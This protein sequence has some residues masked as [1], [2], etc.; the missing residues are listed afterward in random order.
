V[1]AHLPPILART[2]F[3]ISALVGLACACIAPGDAALPTVAPSNVRP[4]VSVTQRA[5][6]DTLQGVVI[7]DPL[8]W[9]EDTSTAEVQAWLAAQARHT[10]AVLALAPRQDSIATRIERIF[11]ELPTFDEVRE[12][13]ER[14]VLTRWLDSG[15]ALLAIDRGARAEREL[16]SGSDLARARDGARIRAIVPSDDGR[17]VALGTTAQ[18]D[19]HAEIS[20]V[21]ATAGGLLPDRIPDLLTTTSGTRYEVTWLPDSSGFIYPRQWPGSAAGSSAER[22]ARG[23]QFVHRLGTPQDA[24]VPIFGFGVSP[25]LALDKDDLPTRV[26]TAPGSDWMVGSIFRSKRNGSDYY[27]ARSA[28]TASDVPAWTAIAG[29]DDHLAVPQLYGNNVYALSRRTADRGVIVRRALDAAVSGAE[30]VGATPDA[31]EIVVPE[32]QGVITAFAVQ[33]DGIYFTEREGGAIALHR[34][35]TTVEDIALPSVGGVHLVRRSPLMDGALFLA[36]SW[37]SAP[38]WLRVR[39]R[40]TAAESMEID[41]A[42]DP[43]ATS[44]IVSE[45]LEVESRD[46]ERVPVSLVYDQKALHNGKLDG[47]AALLIEAYGGFGVSTD[48]HFEPKIHVWLELGGI[49]AYAHV[50]GGGERGDAWHRAATREHKQRSIDDMIAA[51]DALIARGYTSRGRVVLSGT[52]FGANIPGLAMLQRP[53]LFGAVVYEVGQPDEI[54]GASLDPTAARNLA[55]IGDLDTREGIR[56][57]MAS[58]P[59]HQ[60]PARIALPAVLVHSASDDYNFGSQMLVGKFVARLQAANTGQRPVIWLRTPGGHSELLNGDP[61]AAAMVF[62]FLLWQAGAAEYQPTR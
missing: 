50:R 60:V 59:Y 47:S 32:Q 26:L 22:L 31:W 53:E 58:S 5:H 62:A 29:V 9:M 15:P 16:L 55:E 34:F 3:A 11:A 51:I 46:G 8:R 13:P 61:N 56:M 49:Y 38:R 14:I 19:G 54:R 23:R 24:D 21:D 44:S 30:P 40:G 52:S 39:A 1:S 17:W 33:A 28:P 12:T 4:P 36:E 10:E 18:G 37:A 43:A 57:L 48:P 20:V 42:G 41:D 45:N 7:P 35:V 25:A 2:Q 27:A 6:T